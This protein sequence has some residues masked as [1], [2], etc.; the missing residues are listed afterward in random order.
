VIE[1]KNYILV[2]ELMVG[3]GGSSLG[4]L[5]LP[6][7]TKINYNNWII[8]IKALMGAQD[9][10][11]IIEEGYEEVDLTVQGITEA[12]IKVTKEKKMKDNNALYML[13]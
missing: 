5:V 2:S 9:V 6:K 10:W 3:F 7:L 13:Y 8:Q 11:E 4:Q 12:H 1:I